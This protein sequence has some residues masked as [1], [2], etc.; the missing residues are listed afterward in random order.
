MSLARN[1]VP[2]RRSLG[3]I[4]LFAAITPI[5]IIIGLLVTNALNGYAQIVFEAVFLAL[6][7]GS[8]IYIAAFDIIR[9]E[10]LQPGPRAVKWLLAAA[11]YGL[12]GLLALW[13]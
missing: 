11:G 5:G 4:G 10:F 9:D 13:L 12:M 6:A 8:F 7:A 3:L 1:E 2:R